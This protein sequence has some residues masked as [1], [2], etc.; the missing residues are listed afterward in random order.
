MTPAEAATAF[1][2]R[3]VERPDGCW[4]W[5]GARNN[6]GY[7]QLTIGVRTREYAHRYSYRLHKGPIPEGLELDHLCRHPWCV[8]PEHL[9]AVTHAEN[10]RRGHFKR[11]GKT[12]CPSGH[13]YS[14]PN[15]SVRHRGDGR[16]FRM[17]RTCENARARL[18]SK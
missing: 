1:S 3:V 16:Q 13:P 12:H 5:S 7:G 9:E 14:G 18:A 6:L 17:C 15:L 11:S 10:I 8:N 2:D 4:E